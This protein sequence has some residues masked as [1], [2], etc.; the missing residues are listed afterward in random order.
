MMMMMMMMLM[1]LMECDDVTDSEALRWRLVRP[2]TTLN[3][4]TQ[5]QIVSDNAS[6]YVI[7]DV[8]VVYQTSLTLTLTRTDNPDDATV[9]YKW[10]IRVS[11]GDKLSLNWTMKC[12]RD[13]NATLYVRINIIVC[14][15]YAHV[16]VRDGTL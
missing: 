9:V 3:D 4:V 2:Y 7:S 14:P 8:T 13:S 15:C 5:G 11:V 10:L 1:M 16:P 12:Q 6:I